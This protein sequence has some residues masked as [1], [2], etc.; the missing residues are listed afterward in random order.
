MVTFMKN[1]KYHE[2]IIFLTKI[3]MHNDIIV[4]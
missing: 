1:E 3:V 4:L 2:Y